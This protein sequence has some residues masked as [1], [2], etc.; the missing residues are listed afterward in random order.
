MLLFVTLPG[1]QGSPGKREIH[2]QCPLVRA[3][4]RRFYISP[5]PKLL[6]LCLALVLI[7]I[8]DVQHDVRISVGSEGQ[9]IGLHTSMTS[10]LLTVKILK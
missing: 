7:R 3:E 8:T 2:P 9:N 4:P 10:L 5:V 1:V 6:S